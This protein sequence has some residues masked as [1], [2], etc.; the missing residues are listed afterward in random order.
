MVVANGV[1]GISVGVVGVVG[2]DIVV[3]A[4][5]CGVGVVVVGGVVVVVFVVGVGVVVVGVDD[6]GGVVCRLIV[7]VLMSV[8]LLMWSH[9]VL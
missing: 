9:V 5:G 8:V 7:L 3:G 4:V 1:V 2:A 6:V